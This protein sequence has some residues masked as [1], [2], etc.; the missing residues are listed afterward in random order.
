MLYH[1]REREKRDR[2]DYHKDKEKRTKTVGQTR[3]KDRKR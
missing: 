2:G 1:F 3:T